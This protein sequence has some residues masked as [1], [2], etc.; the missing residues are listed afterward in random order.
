MPAKKVTLP[1]T[2]ATKSKPAKVPAASARSAAAK[3]PP[4]KPVKTAAAPSAAL[5]KKAIS[6]GKLPALPAVATAAP[7]ATAKTIAAQIAERNGLGKRQAEQLMADVVAVLVEHL[8]TGSRIR[9]AGLGVLEIRNRP[10]RMGRNPA[11][12]ESIQIAASRKVVFRP[13]KEVKAAV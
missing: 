2:K 3:S 12:G 5:T 4:G 6:R 9:L 7:V 10:A 8:T 11:T 13:A 1:P